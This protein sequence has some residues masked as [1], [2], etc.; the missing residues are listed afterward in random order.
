MSRMCSVSGSL[1]HLPRFFALAWSSRA[2]SAASVSVGLLSRRTSARPAETMASFM[3][4]AVLGSRPRNSTPR[5]TFWALA[6]LTKHTSL[7]TSFL[8]RNSRASNAY[9]W[10]LS[11]TLSAE[12]GLSLRPRRGAVMPDSINVF[13]RLLLP[14][15]FMTTQSPD[16]TCLTMPRYSCG[17][18]AADAACGFCELAAICCGFLFEDNFFLFLLFYILNYKIKREL[19]DEFFFYFFGDVAFE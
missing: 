17:L 19:K 10:S 16:V 12:F 2:T 15:D 4:S 14:S 3:F 6:S 1:L 8:R 13:S 5:S 7:P 9:G 11:I 18:A